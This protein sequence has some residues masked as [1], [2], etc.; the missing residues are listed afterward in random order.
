MA[1]LIWSV[2]VEQY[3][4]CKMEFDSSEA[5]FDTTNPFEVGRQRAIWEA[6]VKLGYHSHMN[7]PADVTGQYQESPGEKAPA[8]K[9][10]DKVTVGGIEFTKTA[11]PADLIKDGLGAT[12]VT[13][14]PWNEQV[15]PKQ[16]AWQQKDAA[17]TASKKFAF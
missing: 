5:D 13:D 6:A 10:G 3:A 9:V 16:K 1:K 7:S 15:N 12:D 2:S 4:E 8:H 17:E 11:E 14:E